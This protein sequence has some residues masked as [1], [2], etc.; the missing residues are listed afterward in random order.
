MWHQ[1][2]LSSLLFF[3][4][5][6]FFVLLLSLFH[7]DNWHQQDNISNVYLK[8]RILICFVYEK[9]FNIK[10]VWE[11]ETNEINEINRCLRKCDRDTNQFFS[12]TY[13]G[14]KKMEENFVTNEL[15]LIPKQLSNWNECHQDIIKMIRFM[16][17]I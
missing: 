7:F 11:K 13:S 2:I 17:H 4:F 6:F 1:L 9:H 16:K 12:H 5:S 15:P 10:N 3:C 14:K 8:L